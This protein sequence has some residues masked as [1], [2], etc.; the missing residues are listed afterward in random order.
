MLVVNLKPESSRAPESHE[1]EVLGTAF[2]HAKRF[3]NKLVLWR[4]VVPS[5]LAPAVRSLP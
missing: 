3:D 1:I 2:P 5:V 4:D